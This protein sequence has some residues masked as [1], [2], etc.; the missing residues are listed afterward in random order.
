MR[1]GALRG[2]RYEVRTATMADVWDRFDFLA[3]A[4]QATTRENLT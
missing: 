3:K 2:G 1:G 4:P